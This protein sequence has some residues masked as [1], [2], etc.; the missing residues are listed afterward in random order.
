MRVILK[1]GK[2][3]PRRQAEQFRDEPSLRAICIAIAGQHEVIGEVL[4]VLLLSP[5]NEIGVLVRPG[6]DVEP[7]VGPPPLE[8]LGI[9]AVALRLNYVQTPA[10]RYDEFHIGIVIDVRVERLTP[11]SWAAYVKAIQ[12]FSG[13]GESKEDPVCFAPCAGEVSIRH[14]QNLQISIAVEIAE[15]GGQVGAGPIVQLRS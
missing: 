12:D 13:R 6:Q 9:G 2:Q 8:V 1:R 11:K 3:A 14:C 15:N 5:V 4:D 7:L 10:T